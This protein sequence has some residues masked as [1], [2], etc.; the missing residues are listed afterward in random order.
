ML[1]ANQGQHPS[2]R[3][4]A[5]STAQIL[6]DY[7]GTEMNTNRKPSKTVLLRVRTVLVVISLLFHTACMEKGDSLFKTTSGGD[8]TPLFSAA[9]YGPD[10]VETDAMTVFQVDYQI[11]NAAG[12]LQ[13]NWRVTAKPLGANVTMNP[14]GDKQMEF[15]ADMPGNYTVE[16]DMAMGGATETASFSF[17]VRPN[18]EFKTDFTGDRTQARVNE[19]LTLTSHL[20]ADIQI[21][22][23]VNWAVTNAPAGSNPQINPVFTGTAGTN[24]TTSY[25][26]D[27]SADMI[28][29]Y[30]VQITAKYFDIEYRNTHTITVDEFKPVAM[31]ASISPVVQLDTP[32]TIDASGSTDPLGGALDYNFTYTGPVA[33]IQFEMFGTKRSGCTRYRIRFHVFG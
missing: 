31:L 23:E 10:F 14:V 27:F 16:F 17:V 7:W 15:L 12:E 5:I 18:V 1:K 13:S 6:F 8:G 32:V 25:G 4:G 3:L 2:R 9:I 33:G 20:D 22:P 28:G 24:I 21:N 26:V 29:T 11:Q 19:T 30:T